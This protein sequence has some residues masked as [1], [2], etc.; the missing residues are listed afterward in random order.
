MELI[1]NTLM[2]LA[3][4]L[5][6]MLALGWLGLTIKP[7]SFPA[8]LQPAGEAPTLPLPA[9]LPA[10]V[11]RFYRVTYGERIPVITAAVVS[12]RGRMAPFG[13]PIPIRFRFIYDL[14]E[15]PQP[16][17]YRADIHGAFFRMPVM[18]VNETYHKGHALGQMPLGVD[19]GPW[20]DQAMNL[21]VWCEILTWLPAALLTDP[22]IHWEPVDEATALLAAPLG[23]QEQ[24]ILVR[25]D[26]RTGEVQYF[27]AMKYRTEH[28]KMLWIN[29]VWFDQGKPW[30]HLDVEVVALNAPLDPGLFESQA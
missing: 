21:R 7:A 18:R 16:L 6:A 27:E 17:D 20:Y 8:P 3:A 22:R 26:P 13:I 12:G 25:F 2:G 30:L 23:E 19:Q 5:A 28:E 10:P 4:L 24:K 14:G 15:S 29:S 1:G 9:G 11:E